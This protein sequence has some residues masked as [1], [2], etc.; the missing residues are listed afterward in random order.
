MNER[1]KEDGRTEIR[2]G[3]EAAEIKLGVRRIRHEGKARVSCEWREER[4]KKG[5]AKL[6]E[7]GRGD[8]LETC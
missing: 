4:S 6:R 1:G 7:E 2:E 3:M 8:T 5:R